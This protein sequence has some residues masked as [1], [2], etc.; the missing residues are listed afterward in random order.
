MHVTSPQP[1][2]ISVGN[3]STRQTIVMSSAENYV[4]E[5]PNAIYCFHVHHHLHTDYKLIIAT[6]FFFV[7]W[8]QKKKNEEMK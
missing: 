4:D 5:T 2:N 8:A 1:K 7:H 6:H 3:F